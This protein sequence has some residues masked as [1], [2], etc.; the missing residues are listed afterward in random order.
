MICPKTNHR[1]L[2][3]PRRHI[4]VNAAQFP[5][6]VSFS[7]SN[8]LLPNSSLELFQRTAP[9][10]NPRF[11]STPR[12]FSACADQILS[13]G[14]YHLP[15]TFRS[16]R[17]SRPQRFAPQKAVQVCCTLLP[18]MGFARFLSQLFDLRRW[19]YDHS[20][21]QSSQTEICVVQPPTDDS[22]PQSKDRS[23]LSQATKS[24]TRCSSQRAHPPF[25]AF[26]S[27]LAVPASPSQP[28]VATPLNV[29]VWSTPLVVTR[30]VLPPCSFEVVADFEIPQPLVHL[31]QPQ[32]LEPNP[33]P[34]HSQVVSNLSM[35]ATPLGFSGAGSPT[36][37]QCAFESD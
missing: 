16:R 21:D 25:E 1:P 22:C 4:G 34:L 31:A 6:I 17:F 10:P 36:P 30:C 12:S 19:P 32:G 33:S 35:P 27:D 3:L 20:S 2:H 7:G 37:W 11:A 28:Y 5:P 14:R 9:L 15:E 24:T 29:T 13:L 26:P 23:Q 18:V 8:Q